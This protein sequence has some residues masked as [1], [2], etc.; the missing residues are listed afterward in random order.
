[1]SLKLKAQN[2]IH[3]QRWH[4]KGKLEEQIIFLTDVLER[5]LEQA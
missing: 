2:S 4:E 5:T 1:V 3:M